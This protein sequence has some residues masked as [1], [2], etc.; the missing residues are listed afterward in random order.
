MRMLLLIVIFGG[1]LA[2]AGFVWSWLRRRAAEQALRDNPPPLARLLVRLPA[3]SDRSNQK[4][5]RFFSRL[6][7]ILPYDEKKLADNT[8]VIHVALI[9]SG[10]ATGQAPK[11]RFML[12][13]PPELIERVQLELVECYDGEAQILEMKD[14]DDPFLEYTS[15]VQ[16]RQAWEQ[17]Q[18]E[19]A[20][21]AAETGEDE[22]P[23]VDHDDDV[24]EQP[25]PVA[26]PR[27]SRPPMPP[28]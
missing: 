21:A 3:E 27:V 9:G 25:L 1:G 7:R 17:Q 26:G 19:A 10:L 18:A 6:E 2:I 16:A 11:V 12:W 8:N 28:R 15:A 5:S 24:A 22:D 4:M 14:K 23:P 20:A 13:C